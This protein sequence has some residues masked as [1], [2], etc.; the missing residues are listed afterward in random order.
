VAVSGAILL[1]VKLVQR[2][3]ALAGWQAE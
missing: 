3:D 2:G 1:S